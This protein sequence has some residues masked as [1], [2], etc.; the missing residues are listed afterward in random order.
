MSRTDFWEAKSEALT[1]HTILAHI[2]ALI[3][4]SKTFLSARFKRTNNSVACTG[5]QYLLPTYLP[6]LL[7]WFCGIR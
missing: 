7:L 2:A 5:L 6:T 3:S 4:C 1:P